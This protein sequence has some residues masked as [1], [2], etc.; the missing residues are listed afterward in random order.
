MKAAA[1]RFVSR[2]AHMLEHHPKQVTLAV[3]ALLLGAGS[4]AVASIEDPADSLPPARQVVEDVVPASLTA[5]SEALGAFSYN[6]YRSDTMRGSD[7]VESLFSRLGVTD[8]AAA[9]YLRTDPTFRTRVLGRGGQMVTAEASDKHAL[10]KLTARWA[11]DDAN[12]QRLVVERNAQGQ[13]TTR[14]ETAPLVPN[15]R[16]GSGTIYSNLFAAVDES[17]IPDGV[18]IQMA[19]IFSGAI[20]FHR[21]LRKGDR[22]SVVYETLDADGEPLRTGKVLSTEFTNAG[23]Q[24]NAVWFQEP[25]KKGAYFDFAGKSLERMFLA[26]PM[27]FSRVTSGFAMRFHP[28]LNQWRAHKGVDYGAPTGTAVRAVGDGVVE[29]AGWQNGYGNVVIVDHG[30]GAVTLYGH[31]SRVNVKRGEKVARSQNI[32]NVGATGWATGPH[33]HFEF[34]ENGIHK[35]PLTVVRNSPTVE[36]TA[37]ARPKFE[38][39]VRN[40]RLVL[41]AASTSHL[42]SR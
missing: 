24:V 6:L 1:G 10:V 35:D 40:V 7:T 22:F 11:S 18:A 23:K 14:V 16:L 26:S 20:D 42:A 8:A 17:R 15:V 9:A 33:L 25:G 3:A 2:A 4:I 36:L 38:E 31:L 21:G 28:I 19:E 29:F 39:S 5:Q 30:K 13:F 32:G 34:R 41:D 12:F 37:Q 27:E